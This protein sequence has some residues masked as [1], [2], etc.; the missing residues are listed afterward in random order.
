MNYFGEYSKEWLTDV[1]YRFQHKK[2]VGAKTLN[3][4]IVQYIEDAKVILEGPFDGIEMNT[5]INEV[6]PLN[7][8]MQI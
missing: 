3:D 7:H 5:D 6:L 1:V 2:P 4:F 8:C